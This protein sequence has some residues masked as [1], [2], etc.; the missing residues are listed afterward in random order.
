[1]VGGA[2]FYFLS[3]GGSHNRVLQYERDYIICEKANGTSANSFKTVADE[4][5][6]V[7]AIRETS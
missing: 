7:F 6:V 3:R 5:V 4:M 1:M 2:V